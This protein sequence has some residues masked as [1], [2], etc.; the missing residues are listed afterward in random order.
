MGWL[1]AATATGW[2]GAQAWWSLGC[3]APVPIHV[4]SSLQHSDGTFCVKPLKQ[5]QV[6]S[7]WVSLRAVA[8]TGLHTPGGKAARGFWG[9]A[10]PWVGSSLLL[11]CSCLLGSLGTTG[12]FKCI[13]AK[14]NRR[15]WGKEGWPEEGAESCGKWGGY[16][17]APHPFPTG[18]QVDG[19]SYLLQEIYGIENKY[20][21]QDS[22]VRASI[23][24]PFPC[25]LA[26]SPS[27]GPAA[28]THTRR[29]VAARHGAARGGA[30][31]LRWH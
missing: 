15:H 13:D 23:P 17:S 12:N 9:A 1:G 14:R 26:P 8:A 20:N 24:Q 30:G 7:V 27:T 11:P 29:D 3:S 16:V 21:T 10:N 2:V 5:K 6:V 31:V 25:P 28:E 22:K 18:L 4:L 19:V